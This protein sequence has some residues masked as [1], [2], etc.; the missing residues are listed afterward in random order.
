MEKNY[1]SSALALMNYIKYQ[2]KLSG[3]KIEIRCASSHSFL[4]IPSCSIKQ[5][6]KQKRTSAGFRQTP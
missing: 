6:G 5:G 2:E 1:N 4:T 3:L